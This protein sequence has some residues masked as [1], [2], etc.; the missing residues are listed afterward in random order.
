ML[1]DQPPPVEFLHLKDISALYSS[2]AVNF[3]LY[4]LRKPIEL[5]PLLIV[6]LCTGVG[7][8]LASCLYSVDERSLLYYGDSV[9]HLVRAREIVESLNPEPQQIGTVW[10]PLPH[11]LLLPFSLVNSLFTSGFAGTFVSLPC[12]AVAAAILY[13]MLRA[14]SG[15]LWI[16]VVGGCLYFLNPNIIYL[17]LTAMTEAPFMLFFIVSAYY[18]QRCFFSAQTPSSNQKTQANKHFRVIGHFYFISIT[19]ILI[20]VDYEADKFD[21]CADRIYQI[22]RKVDQSYCQHVTILIKSRSFN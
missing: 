14:D 12:T 17:G 10:L 21:L 3:L 2:F 9:S 13:K 1:S 5:G 16:A 18:F 15:I 22:A 8:F 20:Y 19:H 7:V 4:I 6:L 11:L